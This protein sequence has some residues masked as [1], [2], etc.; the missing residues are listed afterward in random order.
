[1][2][3]NY[4]RVFYEVAKLSK[5]SEA[6]KKLNISQSALSRSVTL[7]EENEGIILFDRSKNGVTLTPKG[8][9]IYK[10]CEQLFRVE[11]EIENVCRDL[12][13]K[14]EGPLIFAAS[15]HIINDLLPVP[16]NEF[17]RQYNKVTPCLY[18]GTPDEIID[19]LLTTECEFALMF[20]KVNTPQIEYRRLFAE[21]MSLVCHPDLWI[22]SKSTSN[23]K[24][25]KKL[26][27]KYGYISS[28]GALLNRRPSRV[29]VELFG[30][31][32]PISLEVNSQESQK[33]FCLAG[34]GVTYLANFMVKNEIEDG[35][36][37]EIPVE[38]PHEF[39]LWLARLKGKQLSL[40]ARNFLKSINGDWDFN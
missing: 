36:L 10:L 2:E 21:K 24:T 15:D 30:E 3:L 26:V 22:E 37:F 5:F 7:L 38:H 14:C 16:M 33:R 39:H 27:K 17:R 32:P 28:R 34:E 31:L 18:T 8:S 1:M 9:E 29:L 23:D 6:A 40:P 4:L 20:A 12:H 25:L 19:Q 11:K 13:E 35:R